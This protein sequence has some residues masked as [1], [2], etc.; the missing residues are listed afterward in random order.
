MRKSLL[1]VV[2]F[3]VIAA[4]SRPAAAQPLQPDFNL[5]Y[6]LAAASYCAY[7]VG[8]TFEAQ[9]QSDKGRSRA[10]NCLVA[11]AAADAA[12]L[13][14]LK[15]ESE[16]DVEAY[17]VPKGRDFDAYLLVKAPIG[18]ILAFRGTLTPPVSPEIASRENLT[19]EASKLFNEKA[20]ERWEIFIEDWANNFLG[21]AD[22]RHRHSGFDA[23]W[24]TLK[25]N[26]TKPCAAV[27]EEACSML[28]TFLAP[29]DGARPRL[30]ISG[31]SKGGAL[32]TLAGLDLRAFSPWTPMTVY[33]FAAAKSLTKTEAANQTEAASGFW[34]FERDGDLVPTLPTDDSMEPVALSLHYIGEIAPYAHVGP[35]VFFQKDGFLITTPANGR[36]TPK[37]DLDRWREAVGVE[38]A[39]I[40]DWL[41]ERAL[42]Q[43]LPFGCPLID[44][45]FAVLADIQ[46]HVWRIDNSTPSAEELKAKQFFQHGLSVKEMPNVMPGYEDWCG[47]LNAL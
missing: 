19:R 8:P 10:F 11:A 46:A 28:S 16:Q 30:L 22:V 36:D 39:T 4:L 2:C 27:D 44:S 13:S 32:A 37:D 47:W 1:S 33:T 21:Y 24:E 26:L 15:P 18:V 14:A 35:R 34:R 3:G 38:S 40:F 9:N 41:K 29:I 25:A 20:R 12:H 5:A 17:Y 31:H 42:G 7:T 43:K 45:H 23:S 6:A